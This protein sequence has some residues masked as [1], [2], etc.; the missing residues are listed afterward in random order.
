MK[1][2]CVKLA[3]VWLSLCVGVL[4]SFA[5][6]DVNAQDAEQMVPKNQMYVVARQ[7][8]F[9]DYYTSNLLD[10]NAATA[11]STGAA[12]DDEQF[13]DINLGA[14][15]GAYMVSALLYTPWSNGGTLLQSYSI[16][17]S[18]DGETYTEAASGQIAPTTD[19]VRLEL[20]EAALARYVRLVKHRL[21]TDPNNIWE[22]GDLDICYTSYEEGNP[23]LPQSELSAVAK[24]G[25]FTDYKPENMFDASL[26]TSW[27]TGAASDE[28][29]YIDFALGTEPVRVQAL[30]VKPAEYA[31]AANT[32]NFNVYTSL[33]GTNFTPVILNGLVDEH[34]LSEKRIA[35]PGAP[36][37]AF[38]RF[39]KLKSYPA[40]PVNTW[41]ISEINFEVAAEEE[42]QGLVQDFS[43]LTTE[44]LLTD[45]VWK[46]AV[47]TGTGEALRVKDG[48][49]EFIND[50]QTGHGA[51]Y[52]DQDV[53]ESHSFSM[54]AAFYN[55]SAAADTTSSLFIG[56]RKPDD[57]NWPTAR[58]AT[59][60]CAGAAWRFTRARFSAQEARWWRLTTAIFPAVLG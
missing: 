54:D 7:G 3:A 56:Y 8:Y 18:M 51:F 49:L 57:Q 39:Q 12:S 24:Q 32:R 59:L 45:P 10:G 43:R 31:G 13:L 34:L 21:P 6:F 36:Q 35:L 48:V 60:L 41:D 50:G 25:W 42:P 17:V 30:M 58:P 19:P 44:G 2:I 55:T 26:D 29:Q 14:K 53:T 9:G 38:V 4:P 33:D 1:K 20:P 16:A 37:A 27:S 52:V 40:D 15:G 5:V 46:Y 11:W 28:E 23:W 22:A 47:T